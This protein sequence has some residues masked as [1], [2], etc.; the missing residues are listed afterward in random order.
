M[1][2]LAPLPASDA[3]VQEDEAR[4]GAGGGEAASEEAV[5][6]G[7]DDGASDDTAMVTHGRPKTWYGLLM[8]AAD[9]SLGEHAAAR[10]GRVEEDDAT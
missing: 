1:S 5:G 10:A 4:G 3:S 6:G 2:L 8:A 7:S 9:P